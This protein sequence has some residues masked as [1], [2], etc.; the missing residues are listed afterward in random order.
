ML[1]IAPS[2]RAVFAPRATV[3]QKRRQIVIQASA[4]HINPD[5]KK[6]QPKVVD[7]IVASKDISGAQ[8]VACRCWRSKKFPACDGMTVVPFIL[9]ST[10]FSF[11]I[12]HAPPPLPLPPSHTGSHV[13]HNEATGDNVGPLIIKKE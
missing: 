5:I 9:P 13:K 6:D 7:T 8:F 10:S 1:A 4:A 12:T 3:P 11:Y 2:T